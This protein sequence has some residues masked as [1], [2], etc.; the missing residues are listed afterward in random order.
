MQGIFVR[1]RFSEE[2][3]LVDLIHWEGIGE[4]DIAFHPSRANIM[5]REGGP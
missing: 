5:E 4:V 2:I 3:W 1:V